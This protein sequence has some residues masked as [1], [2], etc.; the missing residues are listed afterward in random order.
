M[1]FLFYH[2]FPE[3]YPSNQQYAAHFGEFLLRGYKPAMGTIDCKF[4]FRDSTRA[5]KDGSVGIVDGFTKVLIMLAIVGFLV[6]L[7]VN[8]D[9]LNGTRLGESLKSFAAIRCTYQHYDNPSHHF[10]LSLRHSIW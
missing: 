10:L 2:L 7:E 6:E 5:I 3:V 9:D 1:G 4:P 8:R